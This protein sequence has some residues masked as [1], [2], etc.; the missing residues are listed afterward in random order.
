MQTSVQTL[1]PRGARGIIFD[2]VLA[3]GGTFVAA[4][5]LLEM[6]TGEYPSL[7]LCILDL[8]LPN[9][10]EFPC[11]VISCFDKPLSLEVFPEIVYTNN[12]A[13]KRTILYACPSTNE[14]VNTLCLEKPNIYRK[15]YI[16]WD[17]FDDGTP[18]MKFDSQE[19]IQGRPIIFFGDLTHKTAMAQVQL[20]IALNRQ[21]PAKFEIVFPFI[22]TATMER[23]DPSSTNVLATGETTLRL[24]TSSLSANPGGLPIVSV[25]DVHATVERFYIDLRSASFNMKT[26]IPRLIHL[27]SIHYCRGVTVAF[28][29]AGAYKRFGYYFKDAGYPIIVFAKQRGAGNERKLIQEARYNWPQ[30]QGDSVIFNPFSGVVIVDDLGQSGNTTGECFLHLKE[31]GFSNISA[32]VTHAVFPKN[33][34]RKFIYG[35]KY[36]GLTQFYI[37]D[38]VPEMAY[39]LNVYR[40]FFVL[41]TYR[42]YGRVQDDDDVTVGIV[43]ASTS[44][45]KLKAVADALC[46]TLKK[47]FDLFACPVAQPNLPHIGKQ[48]VGR[49]QTEEACIARL[50]NACAWMKHAI[51]HTDCIAIAIESGVEETAGGLK[52]FVVVKAGNEQFATRY[53]SGID[54][55]KC[56]AKKFLDATRDP[57]MEVVNKTVGEYVSEE[58]GCPSDDWQSLVNPFYPRHKQIADTVSAALYV[59]LSS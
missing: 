48:P 40:P 54:V 12:P 19:I 4:C 27:L 30:G 23:T 15:G 41:S 39:K 37:G 7:I 56:V 42:E 9:A 55:P 16:S 20:C 11:N 52:D 53:S 1:L 59:L 58:Y 2:D 25:Y 35:G 31:L 21:S 3:T 26:L 34:W 45:I 29:D 28:P 17:L 13:D 44:P 46:K 10:K 22:P 43:V 36:H 6:A 32:Y 14:E 57:P 5:K 50:N 47:P 8:H 51:G 33:A 49:Q 18:N 38:T 24:L